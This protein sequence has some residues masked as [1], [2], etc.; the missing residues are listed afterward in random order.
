V[1]IAKDTVV[2]LDIELS[3]LWGNVL[4]RSDQPVTYLHGGYDDLL[5]AVETA[6]EG[7]QVGAEVDLRLEPEDAF[8][9][10]DESL[11]RIEERARFPDPLEIGMRFEGVPGEGVP[12]DAG[13]PVIYRVTDIAEGKVILDGNHPYAGVAVKFACKV[14]NVRKATAA[15]IAGG[16]VDGPESVML[17]IGM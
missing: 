4:E 5:P 10:Y 1:K 11:L 2:A 9:D 7:K 16:A 3:D 12:G 6:L 15:E 17:Q 14:R 13:E 8:G